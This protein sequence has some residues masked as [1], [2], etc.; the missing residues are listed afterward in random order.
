VTNDQ[1]QTEDIGMTETT[2]DSSSVHDRLNQKTSERMMRSSLAAVL[3]GSCL[4][5]YLLLTPNR[6]GTY[7]DDSIYVSTARAIADGQGYRLINLPDSLYQTKYP[8]LYPLVLAAA[9]KMKPQFPQNLN[10]MM[11]LSVIAMIGF[12]LITSSYLLN[13][14]YA[15]PK[16]LFAVI[17]LTAFNWRTMILATSIYS[18]MLF[19]LLTV[20][21]LHV[22]EKY[23]KESVRWHHGVTLGLLIG[24]AFLTRSSGVSLLIAVGIYFVFRRRWRQAML[25]IGIASLF[26]IGWAA[27]CYAHRTTSEVGNA[28]YYTSYLGDLQSILKNLSEEG[29]GSPLAGLLAIVGQNLFGAIIVSI[30]VVCLGLNYDSISHLSGAWLGLAVG[31]ILFVFLVIAA[32]FLRHCRRGFRLLHLYVLSY[33]ILHLFWPYASYDRFLMC[34]L[35]FLLLFLM[36]ELEVPIALIRKSKNRKFG[37]R[38]DALFVGLVLF[39]AISFLAYSYG[40]GIS[41]TLGT[42]KA[43]ANHAAEDDKLIQWINENT[44]LSDILICYRDPKYY[45]YTGRRAISFSWPKPGSSWEGQQPLLRRIVSESGGRYLI[46]TSTDFNHDYDEQLQRDSLRALIDENHNLFT[47]VFT[48]QAQSVIY[49]I[50]TIE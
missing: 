18:E 30:P 15:S 28:A 10:F 42:L 48:P 36:T 40:S 45:L 23:E 11:L 5:S 39:F 41:R 24:L 4:L 35:P 43:V 33:L 26:V 12:L 9:W 21:A 16:T 27:W 6:F 47:P 3:S 31:L 2:A 49:R 8:P 38:I 37:A 7:H 20:A 13:T 17:A 32:G 22:A 29:G 1:P 25:A 34:V 50:E 44:N 46:L 19:A 14:E